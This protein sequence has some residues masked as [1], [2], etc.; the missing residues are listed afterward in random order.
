[1][2][3]KPG[4]SGEGRS[5]PLERRRTPCANSLCG[6]VDGHQFFLAR[7]ELRADGNQI[8]A[9]RCT[10]LDEDLVAFLLDV[11]VDVLAE[12]GHLGVEFVV[13]GSSEAL[14]EA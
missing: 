6:R 11:M 1:M 5:R 14:K 3:A 7:F 2:K 4:L 9:A 8:E 10:R 12:D 13:D